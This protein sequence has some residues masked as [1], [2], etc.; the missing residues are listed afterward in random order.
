MMMERSIDAHSDLNPVVLPAPFAHSG[1]NR[2]TPAFPLSR[3]APGCSPRLCY[4][5]RPMVVDAEVF[6]AMFLAVLLHA[7][8]CIP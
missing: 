8:A 4:T 1:A 7:A 2:A 3:R 5:G 6:I